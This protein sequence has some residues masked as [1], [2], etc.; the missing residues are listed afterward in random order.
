M[1]TEHSGEKT[2]TVHKL[3]ENRVEVWNYLGT[4]LQRDDTMIQIEARYNYKDQDLGTIQLRN[5]D[6]F[7]ETHYADRW[8][9]VFAIFDGERDHF[10]AWY[11]NI[12]RPAAFDGDHIYAEDLALDLLVYPDLTWEI[13]DEDEFEGLALGEDERQQARRAIKQLIVLAQRGESPFILDEK[14]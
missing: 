9:N 12:T 8:Y 4:V 3:D 1:S 14:A 10:K 6:R 7:L 2:I 5:G 13:L 11:C